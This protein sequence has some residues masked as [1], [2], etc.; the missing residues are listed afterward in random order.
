MGP[1][2]GR[3]ADASAGTCSNDTMRDIGGVLCGRIRSASTSATAARAPSIG[4]QE[5]RTG[6][7]A[8][9]VNGVRVLEILG[10]PAVRSISMRSSRL[11]KVATMP[12]A[13]SRRTDRE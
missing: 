6:G 2:H 5:A 1:P 3:L 12:G 7:I 8:L 13:T 11:T 9:H 10:S 4:R